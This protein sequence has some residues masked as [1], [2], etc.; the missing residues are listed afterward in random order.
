MC[1][2]AR[3]VI[4]DCVHAEGLAWILSL[5]YSNSTRSVNGQSTRVTLTSHWLE[6]VF[7]HGQLQDASLG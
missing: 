7:T 6:K 3:L 4:I 5:L 1:N 2:C